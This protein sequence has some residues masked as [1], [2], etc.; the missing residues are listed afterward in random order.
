[1]K[2][3]LVKAS[4]PKHHEPYNPLDKKNLGVSVAEAELQQVPMPLPPEPF[5]GAGVYVIYYAGDFPAYAVLAERNRSPEKPWCAPIYV[6]KAI[7]EGARK[8]GKT[9]DA[10]KGKAL[11]ERLKK[12]AETIRQTNLRIAAFSCRYLVVDDVWIPLAE[13]RLIEMFRP[14]WNLAL[15]GFGN[16]PPGGRRSGQMRSPWGT[17]HTGRAWAAECA[18]NP[19]TEVEFLTA[20]KAFFKESE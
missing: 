6:G 20:I 5:F 13:S 14:L 12:H 7:P 11:F 16:N 17:V 3:P 9:F 8:G 10:S 15:D 1:M 4:T 2:R 18:D 19:K